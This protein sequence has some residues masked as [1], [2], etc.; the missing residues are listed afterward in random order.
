MEERLGF[1]LDFLKEEDSVLLN[2]IIDDL[3]DAELSRFLENNPDFIEKM[4]K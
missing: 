1:L 3:T 4:T 2:H